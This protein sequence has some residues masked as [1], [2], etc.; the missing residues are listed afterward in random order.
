MRLY[1]VRHADPDYERDWITA[2]GEIEARALAPRIKRERP[3][4]LYS[5]PMGRARE[6]ARP[7]AELL[8]LPCPVED[9]TREMAELRLPQG[10]VE[11]EVAWDIHGETIHR[12]FDPTRP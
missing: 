1:I 7:S 2:T 8:K 10:P 6:T 5:S 4:H 11:D 3:T 9:W 12:A